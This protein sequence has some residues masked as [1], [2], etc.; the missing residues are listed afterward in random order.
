MNKNKLIFAI[1]WII[2][3]IFLLFLVYT[4]N[5]NADPN[6][7]KNIKSSLVIWILQDDSNKFSSYLEE[8]KK[9]NEI[10]KNITF[11]VVSFDSYYEY[12]NS[13]VWAFLKWTTPDIFVLNNNDSNFF[14]DQTYPLDSTII[15]PDDFRKDYDVIFSNS[16]IKSIDSDWKKIE[17]LDWVPIWYE[18]LWMFYN[19]RDLKWKKLKTWSYINDIVS[20]IK[21]EWWLSTIWIWNGTTVFW[22]EDIITQFFLLDNISWIDSRNSNSIKSSLATY[23]NFWEWNNNYNS[24]SDD[25]LSTS[26]NNLDLF[27]RGDIQIVLGYPRILE[28]IDKKWFNKT[29]L[30]AEPFPTYWENKWKIL[31]NY[32]YFVI[33][34]NTIDLNLSLELMKY[35][36]SVEWQ[37]KYLEI[38]PYYFPSKLSLL[39]ERLDENL[40][41]WYTIKYKDFYNSSLE[42]ASFNKKYR[43]L[44]DKEIINILDNNTNY[45]YLFENFRKRLLCLSN[46]MI[47]WEN[48]S[49]SCN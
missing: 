49:V 13:L 30:R 27:S 22:V 32:N 42:L 41:E 47:T 23:M 8:F 15:N 11:S 45:L 18:L 48:I 24:F 21:Q 29:F 16:L 35:F 40:K 43:S 26:R 4:L 1:I 5:K 7:K 14:V 33:N 6:T 37:K 31:I 46:K 28:E 12:F 39:D 9:T 38:F 20:N 10:Y 44:Y 25:L 36:Y 3:L 17:Y 2:V 19:F 34:K